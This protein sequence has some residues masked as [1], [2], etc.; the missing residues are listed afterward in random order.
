MFS[1]GDRHHVCVQHVGPGQTRTQCPLTAA[2]IQR[3]DKLWLWNS[4]VERELSHGH[5]RPGG[6]QGGTVTLELNKLSS[7][8]KQRRETRLPFHFKYVKFECLASASGKA[9]I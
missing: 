9:K 6:P 7:V 2:P 5:S 4:E 1:H 3:A 8:R